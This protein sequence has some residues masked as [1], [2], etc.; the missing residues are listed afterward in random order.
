MHLPL[1]MKRWIS[2]LCR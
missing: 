1:G 2:R